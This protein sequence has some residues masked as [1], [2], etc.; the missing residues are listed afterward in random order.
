MPRLYGKAMSKAVGTRDAFYP[1][2]PI[3][4]ATRHSNFIGVLMVLAGM[5]VARKDT[6]GTWGV[7]LTLILTSKYF[8]FYAGETNQEKRIEWEV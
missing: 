2:I 8:S 3:R 4:D 5:L 6:R 1:F 7:G